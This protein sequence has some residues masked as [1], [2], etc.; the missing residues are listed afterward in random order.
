MK[1]IL[2]LIHS[3]PSS[4]LCVQLIVYLVSHS[5]LLARFD[6]SELA[7]ERAGVAFDASKEEADGDDDEDEDDDDEEDVV[8]AEDD[9]DDEEDEDEEDSDDA[10]DEEDVDDEELEDDEEDEEE[11]EQAA[12]RLKSVPKSAPAKVGHSVFSFTDCFHLLL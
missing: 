7:A 10:E 12:K 9:D 1:P 5:A 6:F 3:S 11:D 8:A 2:L 4:C